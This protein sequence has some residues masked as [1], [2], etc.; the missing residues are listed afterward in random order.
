MDIAGQPPSTEF[1]RDHTVVNEDSPGL[2]VTHRAGSKSQ[3]P[4]ERHPFQR[5]NAIE[6]TFGLLLADHRMKRNGP[7]AWV[8]ACVHGERCARDHK[9]PWLLR[10]LDKMRR[11][12]LLCP[13][14]TQQKSTARARFSAAQNVL[15]SLT[16]TKL[17]SAV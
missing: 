14:P 3:Y 15:R 2:A 9:L 16:G 5:R 6:L 17:A 10:R 12:T 11:R 13:M 8:T 1:D 4:E 7:A